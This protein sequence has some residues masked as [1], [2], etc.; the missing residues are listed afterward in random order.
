MS[1][2]E[3]LKLAFSSIFFFKEYYQNS[4]QFGSWWDATFCGVSS[5]SKLFAKAFKI[6][7]KNDSYFNF[8]FILQYIEYCVKVQIFYV[9]DVKAMYVRRSQLA[10]QIL[11]STWDVI[12]I[13]SLFVQSWMYSLVFLH[14]IIFLITLYCILLL[15]CVLLDMVT[16]TQSHF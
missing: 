9:Y 11:C 12:S 15:W 7:K 13:F 1:S 2:A 8:W 16:Y 5:G 6:R 4:K 3:F 10:S 14:K